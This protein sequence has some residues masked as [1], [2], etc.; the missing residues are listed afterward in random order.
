MMTTYLISLDLCNL[1][2]QMCFGRSVAFFRLS[3]FGAIHNGRETV[4]EGG[5]AVQVGPG[6]E[7]R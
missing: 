4:A 3:R 6:R 1:L 7:G 5:P 2:L